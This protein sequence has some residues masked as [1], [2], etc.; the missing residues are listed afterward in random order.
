MKIIIKRILISILTIFI[1][2]LMWATG[3]PY[4]FYLNNYHAYQFGKQLT[5][6]A[7]PPQTKKIGHVYTAYGNL[8]G[9]SNKGV[10]FG[11]ILV[12][13]DLSIDQLSQYY[14]K[15]KGKKAE[16]PYQLYVDIQVFIINGLSNQSPDSLENIDFERKNILSPRW[17]GLSSKEANKLNKNLYLIFMFDGPYRVNDIRCH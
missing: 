9:Q 10:Y 3:F 5:Q 16:H 12:Q 17:F 1:L 11:G 7:L 15:Y 2:F 8:V 4:P 6:L 13:S 14:S